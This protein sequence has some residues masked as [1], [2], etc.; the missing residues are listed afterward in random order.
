M[1]VNMLYSKKSGVMGM[2]KCTLCGGTLD[3]NKRCSLCGLDN[4][5]NDEQYKHMLNKNNCDGQPLTHVHGHA[6]HSATSTRKTQTRTYTTNSSNTKNSKGNSNKKNIV[7]IL[8]VIVAIIGILPTIFDLVKDASYEEVRVEATYETYLEPGSYIVGTHIPEGT[9]MLEIDQ[10]EWGIIQFQEIIDGAIFVNEFEVMDIDDMERIE[11]VYLGE[12]EVLSI[13]TGLTLMAYSSD[14]DPNE[15]TSQLNPQTEGYMI[16]Q[17]SVAGV[18][19]PAGVYDIMYDPECEG[20]GTVFYQIMN[21]QTGLVMI[22]QNQTISI[23]DDVYRNLTLTEGSVIWLDGLQQ[24]IIQPSEVI[25]ST[26]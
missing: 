7:S 12:N 4:T 11:D 17:T 24:V 3:A 10:G 22:E 16:S 25:S 21:P 9:Y 26:E 14:A 13:S 20:E 15:I 6:R 2:A 1:P 23:E 19:F 8:G 5:K 18:D